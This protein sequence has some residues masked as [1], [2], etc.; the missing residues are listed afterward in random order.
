MNRVASEALTADKGVCVSAEGGWRR[1]KSEY[2]EL[3]VTLPLKKGAFH[4][5]KTL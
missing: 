2:G 5:A 4:I 1:K 3:N